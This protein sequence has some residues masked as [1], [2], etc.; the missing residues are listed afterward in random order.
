MKKR[1]IGFFTAFLTLISVLTI[2]SCTTADGVPNLKKMKLSGEVLPKQK[3]FSRV[4]QIALPDDALIYDWD[5]NGIII[6]TNN[7]DVWADRRYGIINLKTKKSTKIE[8]LNCNTM[9][10][11]VKASKAVGKNEDGS[12]II[13]TG[14]LNDK[15]EVVI[16]F[17]YEWE[18]IKP[19]SYYWVNCIEVK[20]KLYEVGSNGLVKL[21]AD[22]AGM[23]G[24]IRKAHK[25]GRYIY[26]FSNLNERVYVLNHSGKLV[27]TFENTSS[28]EYFQKVFLM[29]DDNVLTQSFT[30]LPFNYSGEDYDVL[31]SGYK[32]KL[33]TQIYNL[34]NKTTKTVKNFNYY[35]KDCQSENS[36][37]SSWTVYNESMKSTIILKL[38]CIVD[39]VFR[40][41][42]E[43]LFTAAVDKNLKLKSIL[44]RNAEGIKKLANNR[45]FVS[46]GFESDYMTDKKGNI[47]AQLDT[48]NRIFHISDG[49]AVIGKKQSNFSYEY[50]I[51]DKDGNMLVPFEHY[52]ISNFYGDY[53]LCYDY[54]LNYR[55]V[56]RIDRKGN[57]EHLPANTSYH[58]D[59]YYY[60]YNDEEKI[61]TLCNYAGIKLLESTSGFYCYI[62]SSDLLFVRA[63]MDGRYEYYIIT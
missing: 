52:S 6:V 59:G 63:S 23:L 16:P 2:S 5:S 46:G 53:A 11:Y 39:K 4:E 44:P 55:Y 47:I 41:L 18:D 61:Y 33:K 21:S 51:I 15:N 32:W 56:Y 58:Y 54:G 62:A 49:L 22:T 8:Y 26:G 30:M 57:T 10:G 45:F 19:N 42:K 13:K 31:S 20:G 27:K 36:D 60:F 40:E 17:E 43:D 1:I 12:D 48:G 25:S 35:I 14:L 34:K 50:G 28:Q 38:E 37:P 3:Q 7:A 9:W 24:D 29:S